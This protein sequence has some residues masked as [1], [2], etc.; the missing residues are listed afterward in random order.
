[1]FQIAVYDKK[2]LKLAEIKII[3]RKINH[4]ILITQ[5]DELLKQSKFFFWDS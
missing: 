4:C 5:L 2:V 3:N 1:M